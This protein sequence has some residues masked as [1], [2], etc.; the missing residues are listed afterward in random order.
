MRSYACSVDVE[1]FTYGC[2]S[3]VYGANVIQGGVESKCHAIQ[4]CVGEVRL[5]R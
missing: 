3:F 2:I 4:G 5:M 1:E